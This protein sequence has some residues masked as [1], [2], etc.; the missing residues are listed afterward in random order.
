LKKRYFSRMKKFF[1]LLAIANC[2]NINAQ[3][4]TTIAGNGSN[5]YSGDG[6]QATLA[7]I[8][9]PSGVVFD[10]MG[11]LYIVSVNGR[12]RMVNTT[13][14]ITTLAGT[15]TMGYS[16]D[17]GPATAAQF[18]DPEGIKTDALGNLYIADWGNSR[19]RVI[20][21]SGILNTKAGSGT[22][23]YNG[24][25]MP[26]VSADID[27]PTN[28]SFDAAGNLYIA[29]QGNNRIRK[30]NTSGIISTVAG[31]GSAGSCCSGGYGGDGGPA[32]A[33]QLNGPSAIAFDVAGNMYI[34]DELNNR[35]R[36]VNTAGMITTV[37]GNGTLGYSG[38]EGKATDAEL[39]YPSDIAF[40]ATG[41]LYIADSQN[42]RIRMV[43]TSG[44]ISTVVGNGTS[45]FSG[46]GGFSTLAE[47][48]LPE[49][50]AFDNAGNL[51]FSDSYNSRVRK[52]TYCPTPLNLN[53]SGTD[54]I[55][56]G[57]NTTLHVS[58]A[59]TYVWSANAGSSTL[60]S[61]TV[62][63]ISNAVYSVTGISGGCIAVKNF[64]VSPYSISINHDSVVCIGSSAILSAS[65][66]TNYTWMPGGVTTNTLSVSTVGVYTVTAKKGACNLATTITVNPKPS[67]TIN[68]SNYDHCPNSSQTVTLTAN[69]T[70]ITYA[71][72]P[73]S[74]FYSVNGNIAVI[75]HPSSTQSF[76]V[77]GM[78]G[79]GC[80]NSADTVVEIYPQ[81]ID[82]FVIQPDPTP[83]VWD[84]Y[85]SYP[86][87]IASVSW[88]WGDNSSEDTTLYPSHTYAV[89]GYYDIC[90]FVTDSNGC[91]NGYCLPVSLYRKT[92][93]TMVYINVKNEATGIS[94][95]IDNKEQVSIYPNP[96]VTNFIIE[97][98][99]TDK[100]SLQVYDV[101][102]KVVLSQTI[103]GKTSID[104][105]NLADG[106]YTISLSNNEGLIHKRLIIAR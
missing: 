25:G 77:Y 104:A 81:P 105:S 80:V 64:T 62:S 91:F 37:A 88:D 14:I 102:G 5:A 4:I 10:P 66:A 35:I 38:D 30:V 59:S 27:T 43:N 101:N 45:G 6:G 9:A 12:V 39:H 78:D 33:G 50:L 74:S 72:Y 87:N 42:N 34:A 22:G 3:I 86:A 57:T 2:F 79:N 68:L 92:N 96:A 58:G 15:S 73:L 84:V 23:V 100:Q 90:L 49:R 89:A 69:G 82:T 16:G 46:D 40:D 51:Y 48:Y 70:L 55:C 24:D 106:I 32:T 65:G 41:N 60:D 83:H 21:S 63:P 95:V 29:D 61:V 11:N 1:F 94:Q 19:I 7:G 8:Y 67:V 56:P 52:V 76:T 28:I 54:S 36:M 20:N 99:A 93:N 53:I 31:Y 85:P 103:N 98:N 17:G 97:T 71:W 47:I 44:I 26:A 13:G 18:Y 75:N